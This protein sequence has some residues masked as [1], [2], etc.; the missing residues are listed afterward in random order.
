MELTEEEL[1]KGLKEQNVVSIKRSKIRH[2]GKEIQT[3]HIILT[4]G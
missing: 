4:F 2:D 3:K 1:L